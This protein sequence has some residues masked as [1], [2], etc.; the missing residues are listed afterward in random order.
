MNN[1]EIVQQLEKL[2]T[3]HNTDDVPDFTRVPDNLYQ[4]RLDKIYLQQSKIDNSLQVVWEFEILNGKYAFR[5]VIKYSR[6]NNEQS[7]NFLTIDIRRFRFDHF[8]WAQLQDMFPEMLDSIVEARLVT[9]VSTKN[10]KSYQ[11]IYIQKKLDM[12]IVMKSDQPLQSS[13]DEDE[14]IPF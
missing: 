4:L 8:K 10:G 6:M 12:N 14:D 7:L 3:Y 13:T 5:K 11:S 2:D 9:K 1:E